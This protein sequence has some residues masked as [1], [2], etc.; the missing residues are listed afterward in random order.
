M[1]AL[2][3]S[4]GEEDQREYGETTI[5]TDAA[6][7]I[8]LLSRLL[9]FCS[10]SGFVSLFDGN[11][12]PTNVSSAVAQFIVFEPCPV[13]V[14]AYIPLQVTC[15]LIT[16]IS[17]HD[18]Q[19][20]LRV[21]YRSIPCERRDIVVAKLE[22][23]YLPVEGRAGAKTNLTIADCATA[24]YGD[25]HFKTM[26]ATL[27]KFGDRNDW[28]ATFCVSLLG[29]HHASAQ[30]WRV[31]NLLIKLQASFFTLP[32]TSA[33][34]FLKELHN[35]YRTRFVDPNDCSALTAEQVRHMYGVDTLPGRHESLKHPAY[36]ELIMRM[37][38][39]T[40]R[41]YIS[42]FQEP[43]VDPDGTAYATDLSRAIRIALEEALGS[44]PDV[45]LESFEDW[46]SR[47]MFWAAAGGA[48]GAK[49]RWDS[50]S[51]TER[52][53]K[54]GA[55]LIIPEQHIWEIVRKVGDLTPQE[56]S[57]AALK[58]EA[59]KD[60]W[61]LNTSIEYYLVEAYLLDMFEGACVGETWNSSVNS[62]AQE[63]R[64]RIKRLAVLADPRNAG[65]MWDFSDFNINHTMHA[66]TQL[67][68][69]LEHVFKRFGTYTD[70]KDK[71]RDEI[72]ADI[73]LFTRWKIEAKRHMYVFDPEVGFG[74]EAVR[75]LQS[76]ERSTSFT[77]TF[78]N[79]AY[80]IMHDWFCERFFGRPLLLRESWHQGDD[81]LVLT[82]SVSDAVLACVVYNLLGFAG[83]P[84]KILLSHAG[85]GEFLRY[86]YDPTINSIAGYPIRTYS[87]LIGGEFFRET[88]TD[89]G[90]RAL[91]FLDQVSDAIRRGC[92]PTQ[93]LLDVL[94]KKH[95]HL[96]YTKGGIVKRVFPKL[97]LLLTPAILGGYGT[98]S[99]QP[100]RYLS[101]PRYVADTLQP[102]I[103]VFSD[104]DSQATQ[105]AAAT[106][107][108][109]P[110]A[111]G[112]ASGQGK[113]TLTAKY[114]AVFVD[115]DTYVDR[116]LVDLLAKRRDWKR[117]NAR[118]RTLPYPRNKV[119]LT[120]AYE[121]APEDYFYVGSLVVKDF[122]PVRLS[123]D[124]TA[125]QY[126]TAQR[127]PGA[128]P[129]YEF[130][131][132]DARDAFI[133][134]VISQL[135]NNA[136]NLMGSYVLTPTRRSFITTTRPLFK[137]P[138]V[139][140]RLLSDKRS[141]GE[142]SDAKWLARIGASAAIGRVNAA[143]VHDALSG[144]YPA[145]AL[146]NA[147]ASFAEE[148]DK[149]LSTVR[150]GP[151]V[152]P[153]NLP[154]S[155]VPRMHR[156]IDAIFTWISGGAGSKPS[157]SYGVVNALLRDLKLNSLVT[158]MAAIHELPPVFYPGRLGR[159][160]N[161]LTLRNDG[162][163]I[164]DRPHYVKVKTILYLAHAGDEVVF[165]RICDNIYSYLVGEMSFFPA[166]PSYVSPLVS[167][168]LR[169]ATLEFVE[170]QL[171][172]EILQHS[173]VD[174]ANYVS[175]IEYNMHRA[176][177]AYTWKFADRQR[178]PLNMSG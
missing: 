134:S 151:D 162:A 173:K 13:E 153:L 85:Y 54:R 147:L 107:F 56:F 86:S 174:F 93:K 108:N 152:E 18:F 177:T 114:P 17:E 41:K 34:K 129:V 60:R 164:I 62:A 165:E 178:P 16:Q 125:A 88:S 145:A 61:I 123:S 43:D 148:L 67:F 106:L 68:V 149:Y 143:I 72:L 80:R 158:L 171:F 50:D 14:W 102:L 120:W 135:A 47:R 19:N 111:F 89:P 136:G 46:Y 131:S 83:Q 48:P 25:P 104:K 45:H 12:R 26:A 121:T 139:P 7:T 15:S 69:E 63:L 113:T 155:W 170:Q 156:S 52:L 160:Y 144:A 28:Q 117:L 84:Y 100:T 53:N 2:D 146:S 75:S 8:D 142:L 73:A 42:P 154:S 35:V 71:N 27:I 133:F 141:F 127:L 36:E 109:S 87:G 101:R 11:S 115:P 90:E 95:A 130:Q 5:T 124:N 110:I 167:T 161:V 49:V 20:A 91:T 122:T 116:S 70:T 57:K 94:I 9:D 99:L 40:Q 163:K 81:V 65:L 150:E 128:A 82:K 6:F 175:T 29:L 169:D 3:L 132:Y 24:F 32:F 1:S 10:F 66:L 166:P 138:D 105:L 64:E 176:Y 140:T 79:R 92:M 22:Q 78:L 21:Q 74:T 51:S 126:Q 39:P 118:H 4:F 59:G 172:P 44:A 38:D 77:N 98:S 157:H 112:I 30:A 23:M 31:H 33:T 37:V 97:D 103:E 76:G 96:S 159:L 119:L 58:Y 137:P 168:T 55:L